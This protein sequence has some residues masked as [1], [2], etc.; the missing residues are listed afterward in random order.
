MY[1][2]I[3]GGRFPDEY[4]GGV[5][6]PAPVVVLLRICCP[7][8]RSSLPAPTSYLASE[9]AA[10]SNEV[11][12]AERKTRDAKEAHC[13]REHSCDRKPGFLVEDNQGRTY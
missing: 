3:G 13:R 9:A 2:V 12:L 8:L 10:A 11:L 6:E 5:T 7:Q 1:K 4:S